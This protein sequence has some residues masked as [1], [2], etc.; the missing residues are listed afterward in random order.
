[1]FSALEALAKQRDTKKFKGKYN[2]YD[3]ILGEELRKKMANL[4]NDNNRKVA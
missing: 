3:F 1:M 2:L 4:G